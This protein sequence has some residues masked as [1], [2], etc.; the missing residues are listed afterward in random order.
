MTAQRAGDATV[1]S[2]AWDRTHPDHDWWATPRGWC[3]D[4]D[5]SDHAYGPVGRRRQGEAGCAM[6]YAMVAVALPVLAAIGALI[7]WALR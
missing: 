5:C 3:Y 1:P 7:G 6:P 4:A 2:E